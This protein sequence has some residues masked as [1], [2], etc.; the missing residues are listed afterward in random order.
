MEDPRIAQPISTAVQ[1]SL[2]DV[3]KD[4][5]IISNAV[6]GHSSGEIAAAYC[7][8]AI[9]FENTMKVSY[10]RGRLTSECE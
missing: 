1:L 6:V 8:E 4:L 9:S 5:G 10:H 7:A 2:V 3:L